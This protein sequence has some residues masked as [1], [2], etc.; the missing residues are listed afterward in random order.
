MGLPSDGETLHVRLR[1]LPYGFTRWQSQDCTLDARSLPK[2]QLTGP[3]CGGSLTGTSTAFAWDDV[4]RAATAWRLSLGSRV[5]GAEYFDSGALPADA[6]S[7]VASG[8][9]RDGRAVQA[10]LRWREGGVWKRVDC[11]YVA[12]VGRTLEIE[13]EQSGYHRIS[14]SGSGRVV[15]ALPYCSASCDSRGWG[16]F[17]I[18]ERGSATPPAPPLP[19]LTG[20][21]R[22]ASNRD[23]AFCGGF[24]VDNIPRFSVTQQDGLLRGRFATDAGRTRFG[25]SGC[26]IGCSASGHCTVLCKTVLETQCELSCSPATQGCRTEFQLTGRVGRQPGWLD[27]HVDRDQTFTL[28]C[29]QDGQVSFR[30]QEGYWMDAPLPAP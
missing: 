18:E 11:P 7:V 17:K 25:V 3:A 13:A 15:D 8:L 14:C 27:L 6:R 24:Q 26:P 12:F 16:W 4:G 29:G 10:R 30:E 5:G 23:D 9:P 1:Y 20:I 28:S 2:P 22:G 21:W 19:D